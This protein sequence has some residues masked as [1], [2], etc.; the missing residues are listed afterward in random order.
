MCLHVYMKY[1]AK[2]DMHNNHKMLLDLLEG[3]AYL[4]DSQVVELHITRRYDP[5]NPHV[6]VEIT[7]VL[8]T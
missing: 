5:A 6:E 1:P 2:G 3:H 8:D 4:N 7:E